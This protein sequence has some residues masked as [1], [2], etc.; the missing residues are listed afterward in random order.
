MQTFGIDRCVARYNTA[1]KRVSLSVLSFFETFPNAPVLLLSFYQIFDDLRCN[2]QTDDG[3]HKC[4][5]TRNIPALRTLMLRPRRTDTVC[6]AADRHVLDRT[7]WFFPGID[8]FKLP[9]APFF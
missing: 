1:D 9:D 8:D 5:R 3:W 6:P 7:D 4:R 2:D